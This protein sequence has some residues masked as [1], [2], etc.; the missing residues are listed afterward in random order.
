MTGQ[1][2]RIRKTVS[3]LLGSLSDC[4]G[5]AMVEYALLAGLIAVVAISTL[6]GLGN[7]VKAQFNSISTRL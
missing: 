4:R 6:G 5:A 2:M 7:G 1:I 3:V